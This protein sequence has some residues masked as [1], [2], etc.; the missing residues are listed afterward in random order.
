MIIGE[1]GVNHNGSLDL[2][3]KLVKIASKSGCDYV[4]FQTFI[5]EKV[6]APN[7]KKAD[8]QIKNVQSKGDQLSMIKKL[9][10]SF[11]DHIKL[12]EIC[13]NNN[14]KFLST[15]FDLDSIDFLKELKLGVWKIPSGEITN[16]PYIEK[17]GSFNEKVILSTGMSTINE[18]SEAL[19]IL[20]RQGT[21]L[22][23]I[24]IL[25]CN[26]NYPTSFEDV[27][28]LSMNYIKEIFNTQV[29][30]SDHTLGIEVPIAATALG[31]KIIEKH[32]TISR[33]MEGPDHKASLEPEELT[34]MVN[35]IRNTSVSLGESLKKPT[36]SELKNKEIARKSIHISRSLNQGHLLKKEDFVMLRPGDG[37]SPM[38]IKYFIGRK[39]KS[40]LEKYHKLNEGD[41]L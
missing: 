39:L 31:A 41:I 38:N 8:Y 40:S 21:S 18:I 1:A 20:T 19:N 30:Y 28:L 16:L 5:A 29:G 17:I 9:Q 4:K 25:H 24:T 12:L 11:D 13:K 3:K 36:F 15:A 22:E 37:I 2:A 35:S 33:D 10:L 26:T 32:F 34:Q 7:A 23:N 27:N 6:A 14:I